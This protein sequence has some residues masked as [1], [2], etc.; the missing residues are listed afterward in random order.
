MD[1]DVVRVT[2]E[3]DACWYVGVYTAIDSSLIIARSALL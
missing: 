3:L 2:Q 1:I